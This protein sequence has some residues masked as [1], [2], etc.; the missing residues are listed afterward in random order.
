MA[1][2]IHAVGSVGPW[3]TAIALPVTRG[4]LGWWNFDDTVANLG[5]NKAPGGVHGAVVGNPTVAA[6]HVRFTA[7]KDY[8]QTALLEPEAFTIIVLGRSVYLP[9]PDVATH[10]VYASTF[11][12]SPQDGEAYPSTISG[13]ATLVQTFAGSSVNGVLTGYA[14]RDDGTGT[15][16]AAGTALN[17]DNAQAWGIRAMRAMTGNL[18]VADNLTAA[19]RAV[20]STS[21]RRI[22]NINS[23]RIGSTVTGAY[24]APVDISAIGIFASYLNDAELTALAQTMRKRATRLGMSV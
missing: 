8:L 20:G 3:N 23:F 13:G 2:K 12:G 5:F 9:T 6:T 19:T 11:S 10:A 14:A 7:G 4:L 17:P 22:P 16:V 18:T 21:L 24:A 15:P 1:I